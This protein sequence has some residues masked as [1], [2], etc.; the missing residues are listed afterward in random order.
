M[1]WM[2]LSRLPAS[3]GHQQPY[4][5][6]C[7]SVILREWFQVPA[8]HG[9]IR[10]GKWK[11]SFVSFLKINP[12]GQRLNNNWLFAVDAVCLMIFAHGFICALFCC[13]CSTSSYQHIRLVLSFRISIAT[14]TW[15]RH[16]VDTLS[17]LL[18]LCEGNPPGTGGFLS[19]IASNAEIWCLFYIHLNKL[20]SKQSW[21][22]SDATVMNCE[23]MVQCHHIWLIHVTGLW[24]VYIYNP[25]KGMLWLWY[26]VLRL[27]AVS[28]HECFVVNRSSKQSHYNHMCN[29]SNLL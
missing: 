1:P 25:P 18:A 14:C 29:R 16:D 21:R 19:Q 10:F 8:P 22:L 6:T 15:R 13:G 9:T 2:L 23:A 24:C 5:T 28:N 12:A 4:R 26:R 20:L 11:Y 27:I 17:T 3:P 7:Y